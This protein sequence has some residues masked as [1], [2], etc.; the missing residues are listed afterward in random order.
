ME[1]SSASAALV[2]T[3]EEDTQRAVKEDRSATEKQ[4][5]FELK[6]TI[7]GTPTPN[8]C[9]QRRV[10]HRAKQGKTTKNNTASYFLE[11]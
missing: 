2:S 3:Y 8:L 5:V 6:K 9:S 10:L 4:G 1:R 7:V 11:T